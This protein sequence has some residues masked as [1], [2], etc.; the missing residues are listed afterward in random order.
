L[1]AFLIK[2]QKNVIANKPVNTQSDIVY[3]VTVHTSTFLLWN[4]H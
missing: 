4:L 2:F 3:S 1:L